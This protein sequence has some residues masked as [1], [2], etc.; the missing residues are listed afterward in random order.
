MDTDGMSAMSAADAPIS[1]ANNPL[2]ASAGRS[3]SS[4][5]RADPDRQPASARSIASTVGVGG[6][7]Y[8]AASR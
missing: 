3:Q 1:S 6:K 5:Q 4:T 2:A 8:V 7:P